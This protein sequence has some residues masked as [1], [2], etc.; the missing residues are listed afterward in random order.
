MAEDGAST[1]VA[2][3]IA[4]GNASSRQRAAAQCPAL[5]PDRAD[6]ASTG[7]VSP[8]VEHRDRDGDEGH[9]H[10]REARHRPRCPNQVSPGHRDGQPDRAS[11]IRH[12]ATAG[13]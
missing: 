2:S 12:G 5:W 13:R 4:T 11:G 6:V 3:A 1:P 10:H 7:A 9:R 8:P